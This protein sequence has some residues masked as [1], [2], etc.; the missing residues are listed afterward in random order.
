MGRTKRKLIAIHELSVNTGST[1]TIPI[2][3]VDRGRRDP[4]NMMGMI[5][6]YAPTHNQYTIGTKAGILYTGTYSRNQFDVCNQIFLCTDDINKTRKISLRQ[7][8]AAVSLSGG[9]G[10]TKCNC[11]KNQCSTNRCK[12]YKANIKCN[13]K[14]HS[15]LTCRNKL[16]A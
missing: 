4:R 9:Q 7:A 3:V 12:C 2:P 11:S 13:S 5:V 15:S 10:F 1:V 8:A 6:N 14:C 16:D